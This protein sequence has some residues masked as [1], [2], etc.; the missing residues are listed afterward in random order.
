MPSAG[1]LDVPAARRKV[2]MQS[3]IVDDL[4]RAR[5]ARHACTAVLGALLAGALALPAGA[6]AQTL[7]P[8]QTLTTARVAAVGRQLN[9][10]APRDETPRP[11]ASLSSSARGIRD[12]LVSLARA[13]V[14]RR[15]RT[16]GQTPDQ[17]FDCSGLVR[18]LMAALN[19]EVP[20]TSRQQA[21]QGR[22][23]AKDAAQLKPGDLLTFGSRKRI[24]HIGIYVGDGR[25]IHA[26]SVAGRVIE[27]P[28]ERRKAPLVKPWAGARR[29]LADADTTR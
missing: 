18:Y 13:Q 19:V 28:L 8:A 27:S 21:L 12:S 29:V 1:A 5:R 20:R 6:S 24:S 4:P 23:L 11:F 17:G 16:G 25:F 10:V 15:Y 7:S 3:T 22:A 14:G 9:G 26:S 2:Q